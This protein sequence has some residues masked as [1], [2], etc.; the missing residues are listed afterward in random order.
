MDHLDQ[1]VF[2]GNACTTSDLSKLYLKNHYNNYFIKP[3]GLCG[4]QK[5]MPQKAARG[6]RVSL[7]SQS[8]AAC[9]SVTSDSKTNALLYKGSI[10]LATKRNTIVER[11]GSLLCSITERR[12]WV[13]IWSDKY[14]WG[15]SVYVGFVYSHC[16]CTTGFCISL[17]VLLYQKQSEQSPPLNDHI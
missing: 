14:D 11:Y 8:H 7:T 5:L 6:L 13:Q 4:Q 2:Y 12:S 1:Q 17:Q 3:F 16:V 15:L 10:V 9:L